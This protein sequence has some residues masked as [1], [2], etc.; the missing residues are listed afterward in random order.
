[1]NGMIWVRLGAILAALSVA[2]GAFGAHGLRERL[3]ARSLDLFETAARYQMY[4][5]H[6]LVAVGLLAASGRSGTASTVAGWTFLIGTLIFSGTIY[7]LA[8]SGPRWLGAI[9]P[10]G[11]V[12]MIVGWVALALAAS[13]SPA[14]KL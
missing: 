13:S 1:M 11:G 5:A 8:L 14:A 3:D 2:A 9:T 6:A 12:L 7:A 4:H 10:I